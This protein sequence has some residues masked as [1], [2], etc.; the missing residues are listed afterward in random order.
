MKRSIA[1][2]F[3]KPIIAV[4]LFGVGVVLIFLT[5]PFDSFFLPNDFNQSAYGMALSRSH[6]EGVFELCPGF[7][8]NGEFQCYTNWPPFAFKVYALWFDF[9]QDNSLKNGRLV[10]AFV[11]GLSGCLFFWLL[12][13]GGFSTRQSIVGGI[14]FLTLPFNLKFGSVIYSDIWLVPFWTLALLTF[15]PTRLHRKVLFLIIVLVGSL[16]MWFTLFMLPLPFLLNWTE[17]NWRRTIGV[18]SILIIAILLFQKS[19]IEAFDEN[20][21]IISLKKWTFFNDRVNNGFTVGR[22]ISSFRNIL[23]GC[24]LLPFLAY[25][26]RFK[27]IPLADKKVKVLSRQVRTY[28]LIASGTLIIGFFSLPVWFQNHVSAASFFSLFTGLAICG[29]LFQGGR[30]DDRTGLKLGFLAILINVMAFGALEVIA[31]RKFGSRTE[32]H[33]EMKAFIEA[34]IH[35]GERPVIFFNHPNEKAYQWLNHFTLKEQTNSYIFNCSEP[36]IP[37]VEACFQYGLTKLDSNGFRDF[38]MKK[39]IFI[40]HDS[41]NNGANVI[42]QKVIGNLNVSVVSIN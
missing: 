31:N 22:A 13:V 20:Y 30:E 1:D 7:I 33:S 15:D 11:Y 2:A 36:G 4:S 41:G 12:L 8:E 34:N 27:L 29:I 10:S 5:A 39:V 3:R 18:I 17:K 9:T 38:E 14:I 25:V 32:K 37:G 35:S 26:L 21:M 28:L 23:L 19:F 40:S 42:V 24:F 6:Q 16:F